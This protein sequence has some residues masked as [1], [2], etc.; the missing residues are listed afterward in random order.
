MRGSWVRAALPRG[1]LPQRYA[2]RVS[3]LR[4]RSSARRGG[5]YLLC[6]ALVLALAASIA[7]PALSASLGNS[8]ALN[9]LT[10]E[11]PA[12]TTTATTS[13]TAASRGK[14][15]SNSQR[16]ILLAT[17]AAV[18]LLV[19]IAFVIIRDARRLAPAGDLEL[20]ERSTEH[21]TAV[22][23]RKRRAKAKAARQQRKRNR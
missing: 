18:L 17:L 3:Q 16:V 21:D 7:P 19:G 22:K 6:L 10:E 14:S 15:S 4:P 20:A 5:A 8:S 1:P 11:A 9:R 12:T 13:T 23:L 2:R